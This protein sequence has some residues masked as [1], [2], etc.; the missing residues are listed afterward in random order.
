MRRPPT[1]QLL[2]AL[3]ILAG[4][5][6]R[7][8]AQLPDPGTAPVTKG[9]PRVLPSPTGDPV[10][11]TDPR[12]AP[13]QPTLDPG[14]A[15]PVQPGTVQP[16]I[17]GRDP[18]AVARATRDMRYYP[19]GEPPT[20]LQVTST[21]PRTVTLSWTAVP[22]VSGYWV[23]LQGPGDTTFYMAGGLLTETTSM[24]TSL[25]PATNYSF[26]VS[27]IY[28]QENY[29]RPAASEPV[30]ATT[31][32]PAVPTGFTATVVARGVVSLNWDR[33][34]GADGY[35]ISRT[36]AT[37]LDIRRLN[38]TGGTSL[39]TSAVDTVAWAGTHTYQIRSVYRASDSR[40]AAEVVSA[41]SQPVSVVIPPSGKVRYCQTRG[42]RLRCSESQIPSVTLAA[43]ELP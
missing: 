27:S 43:R 20:G 22:G 15:T 18:S 23:Y 41:A 32:P 11:L 17:I 39:A 40:Q 38:Y 26:K 2:L 34:V 28:P 13:P 6:E 1:N 8:Q 24:V 19:P 14:A 35:R 9:D 36:D 25:L 12:V 29:H 30:T 10:P 3:V 21:D 5:S 42:G 4:G 37:A 16:G 7:L 33:L 31:A